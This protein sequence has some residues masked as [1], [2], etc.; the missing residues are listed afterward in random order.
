MT[1]AVSFTKIC[2][3]LQFI[4]STSS[5][6]LFFLRPFPAIRKKKRLLVR[7]KAG[8][9]LKKSNQKRS[10]VITAENSERNR[11]ASVRTHTP[12]DCLKQKTLKRDSQQMCNTEGSSEGDVGDH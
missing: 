12:Q 8:P 1:D 3:D 4:L 9:K 2:S 6:L 11:A 10:R 7:L 5:S